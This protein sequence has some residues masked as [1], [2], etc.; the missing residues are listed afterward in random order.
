[1]DIII[2]G[3]QAWYT[4]IGSNCKSIAMELSRN[5]RVLYVNMPLDRKT[6]ARDSANPHIR[7]HLDIIRGKEQDLYQI[8]P[9]LWNYYPHKM[10]ES[11]NWLPS[12]RL[13]LL[14]CRINGRRLA[15]EIR[16]AAGL[17]GF[18]DYV[19]FNDNDIFRAFYL[20]DLLRP[21]VYIYY[22]RDNLMG[23]PYWRKHGRTL[24]PLHIARADIAAANSIYLANYLLRTNPN[25]H[26]I[27]QGCNITLFDPSILHPVPKDIESIPRPIIGYVGAII[28]LRIDI[29]ILLHVAKTRPDWSIVLVGPEDD[30]F[31]ASPLHEMPNVHFLGRKDINDLPAYIAN[32]DVCI[33][34]QL[35]NDITAGNYPLKVDEYLA[36]GKP[37]VATRT[38]T[39]QIFEDCV[40]L[41]ERPEDYPQMIYLALSEDDPSLA[42][43][44]IKLARTHT[45]T[46]SVDQLYSLI[47]KQVKN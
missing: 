30:L 43:K 15:A 28:S 26:Y 39:M 8:G 34:P 16:R 25:S 11:A 20:K 38:E 22:C 37:V 33:N 47:E 3:L 18:N 42:E 21:K 29:E 44:R 46:A 6:A 12:T 5:H 7:K 14:F 19:L 45:W 17:M 36:M 40:Y 41:A 31:K 9:N 13:F 27:G 24:E 4:E 32:F 1:M 23:V 35:V 10:L 2:I